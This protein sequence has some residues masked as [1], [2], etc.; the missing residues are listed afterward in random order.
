MRKLFHSV[1]VENHLSNVF[2]LRSRQI[3]ASRRKHH[4]G[5]FVSVM[6]VRFF[7]GVIVHLPK[8]D[9]FLNSLLKSV[10]IYK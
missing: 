10:L 7:A 4:F 2:Y 1:C 5:N 9:T 8:P 3:T 6:A